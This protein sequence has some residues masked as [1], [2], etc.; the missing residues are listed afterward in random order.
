ML[1]VLTRFSSHPPVASGVGPTCD[2]SIAP[3][4]RQFLSMYLILLAVVRMSFCIVILAD[5]I[6]V[7][8]RV[9]LKTAV[10]QVRGGSPY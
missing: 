10:K 6:S 8:L 1:V 9:V 3:N 7:F 4:I 2:K 5:V